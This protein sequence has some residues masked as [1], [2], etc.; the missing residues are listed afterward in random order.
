MA[1]SGARGASWFKRNV[2]ILESPVHPAEFLEPIAECLRCARGDPIYS[3][4]ERS[5]FWYRVVEGMAKRCLPRSDGKNQIIDF[6]QPEDWFGLSAGIT[7]GFSAEAV[8]ANSLIAR[9]PRHLIHKTFEGSPRSQSW[10]LD[11]TFQPIA[12]ME[13]RLLVLGRLNAL[14]KV[15]A[16]LLELAARSPL[17]ADVVALP[18]SRYEIADY[19][20]LSVETVSRSITEWRVRGAIALPDVHSI[21]IL[22]RNAL[23]EGWDDLG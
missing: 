16:F 13:R 11:L 23:R 17:G 20:A 1:S 15:A 21:R 4:G 19:L 14:Q 10:L 2:P 3:I 18:M 5:G 7:H 8:V 12:R 22:D 6:L 9:Y